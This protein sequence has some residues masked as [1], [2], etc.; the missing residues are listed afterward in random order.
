MILDPDTF[1]PVPPEHAEYVCEVADEHF[2]PRFNVFDTDDGWAVQVT[3]RTAGAVSAVSQVWM[4][5]EEAQT[6]LS[7]AYERA[8]EILVWE[9]GLG[10][11]VDL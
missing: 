1:I 2:A 6:A 7:E 9:S 8:E 10:V 3:V 5:P 4:L 11:Q